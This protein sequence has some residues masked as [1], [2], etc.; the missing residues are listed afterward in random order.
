MH[1]I[2]FKFLDITFFLEQYML[3]KISIKIKLSY[4]IVK[5]FLTMTLRE[6]P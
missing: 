2:Y 3:E 1:K 6:L 5:S 4:D